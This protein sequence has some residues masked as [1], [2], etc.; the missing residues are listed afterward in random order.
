MDRYDYLNTLI[1]KFFS[2]SQC[3]P[4]SLS[5]RQIWQPGHRPFASKYDVVIAHLASFLEELILC[6][7]INSETT[8]SREVVGMVE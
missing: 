6:R 8:V 7:N 1:P 3:S 2:L 4:F 5:M